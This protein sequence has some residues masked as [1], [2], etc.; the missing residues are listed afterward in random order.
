MEWQILT[1]RGNLRSCPGQL[2]AAFTDQPQPF[3]KSGNR[4]WRKILACGPAGVP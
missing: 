3:S 4:C 2:Q 1:F